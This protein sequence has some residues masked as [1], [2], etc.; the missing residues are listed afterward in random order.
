[1][2]SALTD[3]GLRPAINA[4]GPWSPIGNSTPSE[5]VIAAMGDAARA[6]LPVRELQGTASRMIAEATGA[7]AGY[8]TPG[9]AAGITLAVAACIAGEDPVRIKSLPHITAPPRNVVMFQQHRGYYDFAVRATGAHLR[10]V[11]AWAP[12]SLGQMTSAIDGDVACVFYDCS[13]P[14][15]KDQSGIPPLED[16]VRI[17]HQAG[18]RVVADASMALPPAENLR[19]ILATGADAAIYTASKAMQGPAASGFVAA[20]RDMV[21][22]ITLQHQDLDV[23]AETTGTPDPLNQ[24]MGLGRSLKIGKEQIVG[25]LVA[26]EEYQRRD[27]GDDQT[28]WRA[29]LERIES[30]IT[31]IDGITRQWLVSNEGRAPYLLVGFEGPLGETRADDISARLMADDER[32]FVAAK[33]NNT[34]CLGA[35][36]LCADDVGLVAR[37]LREEIETAAKQG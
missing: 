20:A 17:A 9:A 1:M 4:T 2:P 37:R 30:R 7:E 21:R 25:M 35:E 3:F 11:D 26:L 16:V 36:N 13:G 10:L 32:I 8:A 6:F 23:V 34:L 18:V 22:S 33:S 28:N 24:Y 31:D 14:P 29:A 15:F 19:A 5:G 12:D 27:H